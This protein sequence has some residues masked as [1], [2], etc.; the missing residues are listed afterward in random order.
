ML[1]EHLKGIINGE[2]KKDDNRE[3]TAKQYDAERDKSPL[4]IYMGAVDKTL[5]AIISQRPNK[6][7]YTK[8]YAHRVIIKLWGMT[9]CRPKYSK[10][11]KISS[12]E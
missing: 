1:A 7:K 4:T 8:Q 10:D 5:E 9:T 2:P 6:T 3:E 11:A 12:L